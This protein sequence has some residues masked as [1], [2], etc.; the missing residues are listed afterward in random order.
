MLK[1]VLQYT[2]D[3]ACD[4]RQVFKCLAADSVAILKTSNSIFRTRVTI[5][6][7]DYAHLN[8]VITKINSMTYNEVRVVKTKVIKEEKKC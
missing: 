6:V 3:S 7:K 8:S 1:A 4:G 2:D 5:L